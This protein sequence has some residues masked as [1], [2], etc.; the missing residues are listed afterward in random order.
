M[1]LD[2]QELGA[3]AA[4]IARELV[5]ILEQRMATAPRRE[6]LTMTELAEYLRKS[7][8]TVRRWKRDGVI[9]CVYLPDGTT[10]YHYPAVTAALLSRSE[11]EREED[12]A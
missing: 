2:E 3:V 6:W 1:R 10:K 4:Q 11:H 12:T 9:P 8:P 7:I 5:P